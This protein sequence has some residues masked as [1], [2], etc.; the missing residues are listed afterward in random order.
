MPNEINLADEDSPTI[1]V[2]IPDGDTKIER[3]Y[4]FYDL[5]E[6][7]EDIRAEREASNK[8]LADKKKPFPNPIK[9][10]IE[11]IRKLFGFPI[12]HDGKSINLTNNQAM[13]IWKKFQ[14]AVK[15]EEEKAKKL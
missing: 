14:K 10:N 7:A 6:R 8:E 3:K 1:L 4:E 13:A 12:K 11:D 15:E 5:L 9:S 2:N